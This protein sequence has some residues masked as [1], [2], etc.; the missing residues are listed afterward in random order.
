M[1]QLW[2]SILPSPSNHWADL[3]ST[4]DHGD[5]DTC[6]IVFRGYVAD[7]YDD[8]CHHDRLDDTLRKLAW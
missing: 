3:V 7:V 5:G 8:I 4:V 6:D 2:T 1:F